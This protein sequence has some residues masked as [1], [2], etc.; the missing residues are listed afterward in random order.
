MDRMK[1]SNLTQYK[2]IITAALNKEVPKE[3]FV[4]RGVPV[5][6]IEALRSGALDLS[7][8]PGRGIM[9]IITGAGPGA[10]SG[11]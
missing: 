9:V 1:R 8:E 3:W 5:H 2:L 10:A 6:T 4:S 11:G 7:T